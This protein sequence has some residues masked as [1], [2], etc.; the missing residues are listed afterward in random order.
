MLGELLGEGTGKAV[1][2]RVLEGEPVRLEVSGQGSAKLL[3]AEA[4]QIVTYWQMMR[5]VGGLYGEGH[6]VLITKDGH[7]ADGWGFG[8]GKPTGPGPAAHWGVCARFRAASGGLARLL[9][10]AVVLEWDTDDSGGFRW[11]MWEWK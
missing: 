2:V 9:A 7:M 5:P 3:G 11:K 1:V 4:T 8:I 6:L 10:T